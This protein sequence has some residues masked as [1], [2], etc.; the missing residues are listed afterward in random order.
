MLWTLIVME[1]L[2]LEQT[3]TLTQWVPVSFPWLS[4][5]YRVLQL[6]FGGA[7]KFIFSLALSEGP[8]CM[9]CSDTRVWQVTKSIFWLCFLVEFGE[10]T[11]QMLVQQH[12]EHFS[13]CCCSPQ[14]GPG[15]PEGME[16]LFSFFFFFSSHSSFLWAFNVSLAD[17][18]DL[19][20]LSRALVA[21]CKKE[22]CLEQ[23]G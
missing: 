3:E 16:E 19:W 13:P 9:M 6:L 4:H 10:I 18:R 22:L 20:P 11:S 14:T 2:S 23:A 1:S 5:W 8:C 21:N 7:H 17:I 12:S 15:L